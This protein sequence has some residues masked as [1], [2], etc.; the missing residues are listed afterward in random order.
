MPRFFIDYTPNERAE[1]IGG[2][3]KHI[4]L[5][6]RMKLGDE[7]VLTNSG[8]DYTCKIESI[9]PEM[10]TLSVKDSS[11][12]KAEP[13]V[14]LT[15]YQ[16][17]PKADKLEMIVQKA[18]ELGA[19]RIVP[20]LTRRCISRPKQN[21]FEK[22]RIRLEKIAA[23]AA[24]Q[25]GRGIVPEISSIMSFE[26]A[27]EDMKKSDYALMCYENGGKRFNE[28]DLPHDCSISLLIGSEGGFDMEEAEQALDAGV[29]SIWLGERI[30]RCET[31][32]LAAI[33][34]I[35]HITEN[36]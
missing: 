7:I 36:F 3:A 10:V 14:K 20:V 27:L 33:S 5:S 29:T 24:K 6:L 16:A 18:V 31:A 13:S 1:I 26:Q 17:M 35:M 22:K 23:E 11:P 8:V 30:L 28:I 4:A 9:N 19:C 32:P 25:S 34:I 12:C 21:D 15:L 2:D